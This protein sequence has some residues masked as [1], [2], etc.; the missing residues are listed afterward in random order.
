[1]KSKNGEG[2]ALWRGHHF[3]PKDRCLNTCPLTWP[4]PEFLAAAAPQSAFRRERTLG[5][6]KKE[7]KN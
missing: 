5:K 7:I 1:M 3:C 2:K 6:K 4:S